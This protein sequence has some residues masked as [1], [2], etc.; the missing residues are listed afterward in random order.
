MAACGDVLSENPDGSDPDTSGKGDIYGSDNR[1]ELYDPAVIANH[2]RAAQSTAVIIGQGGFDDLNDST[3]TVSGL[4]LAARMRATLGGPLC[5]TE[6]FLDQPAP[7]FCSA[8]L[9]A[10]DLVATAGHCV[11]QATAVHQGSYVFG[12]GYD[13]AGDSGVRTVPRQ[14]VYQGKVVVG[15]V[16]NQGEQSAAD[17]AAREYWDDWAVVQ[18]DRP[19]VG[20]P[21]LPIRDSAVVTG[22]VAT[23]IGHPSG[24]PTKVTSGTV[25]DGTKSRYF[26]TDL[27]IYQGNS[28]SLVADQ[29]GNAVGI[30]IRGSGGNSFKRTADGCFASKRCEEV[31][32]TGAC[33]GNHVMR[34]HVLEPFVEPGVSMTI[35]QGVAEGA[36]TIPDG[37]SSGLTLSRH[38]DASGYV[39][40]VTL[41]VNLSHPAPQELE[42]YLEHDG[43]TVAVAKRPQKWK[44]GE[45][46]FSRTTTGFNNELAAGTWTLKVV[47]TAANGGT[48]QRVE[49]WQLVVGTRSTPGAPAT[50]DEPLV[51]MG[52]FVGTPCE[53]DAHCAFDTASGPGFCHRFEASG[54]EHGFCSIPCEGFCPDKSGVAPTFCVASDTAGM[55]ICTQ[56]SSSLNQFC[57]EIPG[58]EVQ[59]LER[60]IGNSTAAAAVKTVCAPP[61][62]N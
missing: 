13:S 35:S 18:L 37:A 23:A 27:D 6:R 21:V 59:D 20:R 14:D 34:A 16:Y 32:L 17:T 26:N 24:L 33:I 41:N 47:D 51:D 15:H 49:W 44:G 7:G 5:S 48:Y 30:V 28:G 12:F 52:P 8:F 46:R 11:N 54:A 61:A 36:P 3:A 31:D 43:K 45:I 4:N 38:V 25:V 42:F 53:A 55:G 39:A 29:S 10:P 58:T 62:G 40:Y 56:Q 19:V 50:P 22:E 2:R 9:I 60:F 1:L 57:A